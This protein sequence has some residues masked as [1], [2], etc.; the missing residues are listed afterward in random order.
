MIS[1]RMRICSRL[2]RVC[3]CKSSKIFLSDCRG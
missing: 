2:Y 1:S 3:A